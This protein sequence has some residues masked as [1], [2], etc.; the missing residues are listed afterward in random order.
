MLA[1]A[2]CGLPSLWLRWREGQSLRRAAFL[3]LGLWLLLLAIALLNPSH[4]LDAE[5]IRRFPRPQWISWLPTTV[6]RRA[7]LLAQL[8][9]VAALLQ[10]TFFLATPVSRRLV[11][12]VWG[13]AALNGFVLALVGATFHLAGADRILGFV[14]VPEPSYFFATFFYKSHWAA[15]GAL[16]TA[17]AGALALAAWPRALAGDPRARANTFLFGVALVFTAITLPMPGSRAGALLGLLLVCGAG[18]AALA[19]LALNRGLSRAHRWIAAGTLCVALVGGLSYGAELYRHR[20][21]DWTRTVRQLAVAR[22]GESAELRFILARDTWHMIRERPWFG[23]GV[24]AYEI[25]FPLFAGSELRGPDH[26]PVRVQFAHDDWLQLTAES[27]IVGLAVL[28]V[29]AAACG[30]GGW[31]R[32]RLP[33]RWVLGG[34]ALIALYAWVDFPLYNPAVLIVWACLLSTACARRLETPMH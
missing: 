15:F 10:A 1:I 12:F 11:R 4:M 19:V 2:C 31:R 5:E 21:E 25:V 24:G 23:W 33:G 34:C 6:D 26:R 32:S 3:P 22:R 7:T 29:S 18:A 27:G 30:A 28:V 17:A 20:A 14:E 16:A 8:P 9:W 13:V